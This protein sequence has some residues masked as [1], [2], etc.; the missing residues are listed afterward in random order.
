MEIVALGESEFSLG[1]ELAGVRSVATSRSDA[2]AQVDALLRNEAVGILIIS[3]GTFQWLSAETRERL[4]RAP[5]PVTVVLSE[6]DEN[7]ELRSMIIRSIGVDLWKSE[8]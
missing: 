3:H 1:F 7:Q 8:D 2:E 5:R 6:K 4:L